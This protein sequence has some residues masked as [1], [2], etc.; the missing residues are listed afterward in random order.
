MS[1]LTI[2]RVARRP[3]LPALTSVRFF[4]ALWVLVFHAVSFSPAARLRLQ[5]TDWLSNLINNGSCGVEFFFILSGFILTYNY[6]EADLSGPGLAR[7]RRARIARIAPLYVIGLGL[8]APAV[9]QSMFTQGPD[10]PE[11]MATFTALM[12]SVCFLQAWYPPAA[13]RWNDPGWSISAEAFFYGC[14]PGL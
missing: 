4:A 1:G 5:T 6:L 9:V 10:L 12:L 2:D 8:A 11:L 3:E 13:V 7:Y 14:S